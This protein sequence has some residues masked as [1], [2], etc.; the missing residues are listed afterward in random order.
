MNIYYKLPLNESHSESDTNPFK[1]FTN[2]SLLC[3]HA[4]RTIFTNVLWTLPTHK[5]HCDTMPRQL[6][7]SQFSTLNNSY[8][9]QTFSFQNVSVSW[10]FLSVWLQPLF[11]PHKL[12]ASSLYA[13]GFLYRSS[14]SVSKRS[15]VR[16][17][18]DAMVWL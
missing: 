18:E 10:W 15:C 7:N 14:K 5:L 12:F 11:E 9:Q 1:H 4:V 3:Q 8:V 2:F 17:L 6:T 13:P 16:L